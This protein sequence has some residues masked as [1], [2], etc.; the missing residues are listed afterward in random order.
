MATIDHIPVPKSGDYKELRKWFEAV[1]R[2][3]NVLDAHCSN[4]DGS[5]N[6]SNVGFDIATSIGSSYES[7][8]P[9]G[10]GATNTWTALNVVPIDA[11]WIEVAFYGYLERTAGADAL[12][13]A[14]VFARAHGASTSAENDTTRMLYLQCYGGTTIPAYDRYVITKKIPVTRC[15]FDLEML[16]QDSTAVYIDAY[17]VGYGYNK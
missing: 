9:T 4:S 13:L 10:A 8:G 7:V 3:L 15:V 14:T 1:S 2:R 5:P 17:L 16:T 11:H 6:V 12:A